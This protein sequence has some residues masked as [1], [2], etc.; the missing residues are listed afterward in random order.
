MYAFMNM[1]EKYYVNVNRKCNMKAMVS[2]TSVSE[3]VQLVTGQ[4]LPAHVKSLQLEV[5]C[6]DDSGSELQVPFVKYNF[7]SP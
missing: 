3:A 2:V 6:V 7:R 5:N 1:V 4:P